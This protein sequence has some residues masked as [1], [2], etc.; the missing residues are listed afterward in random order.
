M[1]YFKAT[2][3]PDKKLF[4][5]A[6]D[7]FAHSNK[8]LKIRLIVGLIICCVI[9]PVLTYVCYINHYDEF[10]VMPTLGIILVFN[11]FFSPKILGNAMY[12]SQSKK[13]LARETTYY[14]SD[15]NF[16]AEGVD[17]NSTANYS[18]VEALLETDGLYCL[19]INKASAIIIPKNSIENPLCDPKTFL[20]SKVGQPFTFVKKKTAGKAVAKTLGI[21]ALSI[22]LTLAAGVIGDF[23]LS[24]PQTFS[25]D[26]YSVTLDKHFTEWEENR[27][28]DYSLTSDEVSFI[29]DKYT[30]KDAEYALEDQYVNLEKIVKSFC[31]D[32]EI[33]DTKQVSRNNYLIKYFD[34]SEGIEFYNAA[35]IQQVGDEYW[36]TQLYCEKTHQKDYEEQF[37]KWISSIKIKEN[38]PT[39]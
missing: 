3:K 30:Q 19:Y 18:A 24:K 26:N 2:V 28:D 39:V 37:D 14:F 7:A 8:G 1:D 17:T 35:C 21:F 38:S 29:V 6:G 27:E 36:I 5:K 20:E 13:N 16:R 23:Y 32:T 9:W 11:Y 34:E 4:L 33:I 31:E 10:F 22:F 15:N 12:K 25:Y